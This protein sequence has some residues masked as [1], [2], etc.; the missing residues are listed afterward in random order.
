MNTV[1]LVG[2]MHDYQHGN[3]R[4]SRENIQ[5]FQ[6][7][8]RL[9]VRDHNATGIAEEN[10]LQAL[11]EA[12]VSE[13]TVAQVAAELK[14]R[15]KYCDLDRDERQAKGIESIQDLKWAKNFNNWTEEELQARIKASNR[16]REAHWLQELISFNTSPVVFVCGSDHVPGFKNLL[17][18]NKFQVSVAHADWAPNQSLQPTR[19]ASGARG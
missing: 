1:I 2:T 3:N 12:G 8:L 18:E 9:L 4:V 7:M 10:S 6:G 14:V 17:E 13:S 19:P 5:K 11:K 16:A 15:Y